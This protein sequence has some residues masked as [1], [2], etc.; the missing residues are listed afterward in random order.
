MQGFESVELR[1]LDERIRAWGTPRYHSEMA[2]GID[3]LACLSEPLVLHPQGNAV[4]VRSGIAIHIGDPHVAGIIVP[5]SGLGHKHGLVLGNLTGILDA[6][7]TGELMISCWNRSSL[8]SSPVVINPGDRIAQLLFLPI[9][10]P[11]IRL[12][13]E[14]SATTVRGGGGFGSTGHT[15]PSGSNAPGS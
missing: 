8:G 5:R 15:Q 14:F 10:R 6:D 12:V 13:D 3:L 1:I 4:L 2:A 9:L 11:E 7:F